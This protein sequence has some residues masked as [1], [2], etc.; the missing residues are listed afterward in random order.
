MKCLLLDLTSLDTPSRRRGTGRYVRD[1]A[2]GLSRLPPDVLGD[3]KLLGLTHLGMNGAFR[4]T[5]RLDQFEGSPQIDLPTARNH[6]H[7]AYARRLGMFRAVR[8]IGAH[9]VHFG[10]P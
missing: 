8:R 1:L 10:D 7:W 5:D 2:V 4:V 3:L 9:A 6:Y